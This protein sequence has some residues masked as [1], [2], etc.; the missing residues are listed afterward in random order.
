MPHTKWKAGVVY[1]TKNVEKNKLNVERKSLS[2]QK[3]S[4]E[5]VMSAFTSN[6]G[7]CGLEFIL[8]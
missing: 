2:Q 8:L 4:I 7:R 5:N 1:K 6:F 3:H